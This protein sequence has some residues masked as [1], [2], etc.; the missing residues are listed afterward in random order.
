[1]MTEQ[2][3][4]FPQIDPK[5]HRPIKNC[6]GKKGGKCNSWAGATKLETKIKVAA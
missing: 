5:P 6:G 3:V 1:M 4:G 2:I